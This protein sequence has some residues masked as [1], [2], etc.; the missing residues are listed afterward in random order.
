MG[1]SA[2]VT[3]LIKSHSS[4]NPGED[5]RNHVAFYK[6]LGRLLFTVYNEDSTFFDFVRPWQDSFALLQVVPALDVPDFYR[7]ISVMADRAEKMIRRP[8]RDSAIL[9]KISED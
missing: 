7:V 9:W 4:I 1:K 2:V 5:L 6:A 3:S 8:M